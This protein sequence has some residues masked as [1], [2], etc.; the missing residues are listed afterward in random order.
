MMTIAEE[1]KISGADGWAKHWR[2]REEANPIEW[3]TDVNIDYLRVT[4]TRPHAEGSDL[5]ETVIVMLRVLQ[6]CVHHYSHPDI[7]PHRQECGNIDDIRDCPIAK[8]ALDLY[9]GES[10]R[11]YGDKA[12]PICLGPVE[13]F[14]NYLRPQS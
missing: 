12:V 8:K 5:P 9:E 10:L 13:A 6:G 1:K 4:M 11:R 7:R 14:L 3:E 2:E